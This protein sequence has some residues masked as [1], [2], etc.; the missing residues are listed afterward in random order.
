MSG[1]QTINFA[2][3]ANGTTG[4][5]SAGALDITAGDIGLNITG[6]LNGAAYVIATYTSLTGSTFAA[7]P[8]LPEGYELD[9][10]YLGNSIALVQVPEPAAVALLGLA[11]ITLLGRRRRG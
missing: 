6:T 1:S 2:V 8:T 11:G 9:T 10:D 5:L 7:M 3:N 4:L